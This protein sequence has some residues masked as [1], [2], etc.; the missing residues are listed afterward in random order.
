MS[1]DVGVIKEGEHEMVSVRLYV[2]DVNDGDEGGD[3][4]VDDEVQK[5][6]M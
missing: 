4:N 3:V 6:E 5:L 1:E 2:F